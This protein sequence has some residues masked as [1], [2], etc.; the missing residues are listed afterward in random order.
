[1]PNEVPMGA[2]MLLVTD[3]VPAMVTGWLL[4]VMRVNCVTHVPVIATSYVA[5]AFNVNARF[6]NPEKPLVPQRMPPLLTTTAGSIAFGVAMLK[7][8]PLF[9]VTVPVLLSWLVM[10]SVV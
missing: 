2:E 7:R 6:M 5:R 8:A 9:T 1:M 10:L 3:R 4:T